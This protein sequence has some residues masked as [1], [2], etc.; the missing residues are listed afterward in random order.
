[1]NK[2][3]A[4]LPLRK[5][6]K[7]IPG[8]NKKKLLGRPLYQWVLGEAIFSKLDTIYVF[9]DDDEI[10]DAVEKDYRW[11]P[12]VKIWKRSPESASDTASTEM[13]MNELAEGISF[14]FDIF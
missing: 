14:D 13:P 5:G 6:S 8:K 11:T 4:V 10:I 2:I 12:K 1:M 7:G 3:I 9:T